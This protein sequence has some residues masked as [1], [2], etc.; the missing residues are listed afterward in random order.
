MRVCP[1]LAA[2]S[3]IQRSSSP[4]LSRH[5]PCPSA[6]CRD[7]PPTGLSLWTRPDQIAGCPGSAQLCRCASSERPARSDQGSSS[8][9]SVSG[10]FGGFAGAARQAPIAHTRVRRA[11]LSVSGNHSPRAWTQQAPRPCAPTSK[12]LT[13]S[14]ASLIARPESE[15]QKQT[16]TKTGG[17]RR[18]WPKRPG[19]PTAGRPVPERLAPEPSLSPSFLPAALSAP[20]SVTHAAQ[21]SYKAQREAA[22]AQVQGQK[23]KRGGARGIDFN[24]IP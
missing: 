6:L 16:K 4:I 19:S 9:P 17:Y 24:P 12:A 21:R 15:L 18:I 8:Q 20:A 13:L 5:R 7:R 11:R 14:S 3:Q 22:A 2:K 23:L 10:G 1:G